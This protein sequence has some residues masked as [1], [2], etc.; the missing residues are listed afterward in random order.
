[1]KGKGKLSFDPNKSNRRT[2]HFR[3]SE[4]SNCV[5]SGRR[6]LVDDEFFRSAALFASERH[7]TLLP[8]LGLSRCQRHY[9]PAAKARG[10]LTRV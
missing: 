8:F 4:E 10:V 2:I 9:G 1:M 7:K 5:Q 6:L 3:V